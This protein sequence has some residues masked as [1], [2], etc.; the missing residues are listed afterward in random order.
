MNLTERRAG[1]RP[2]LSAGA[3]GAGTGGG[4]NSTLKAIRFVRLLRLFKLLR[5]LRSVRIFARWE[6]RMT[7]NYAML[8]LNKFLAILLLFR[9]VRY[10]RIRS[11]QS[12]ISHPASHRLA[13]S[14]HTSSR[15]GHPAGPSQRA[16]MIRPFTRA[17]ANDVV[18]LS[19]PPD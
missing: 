15:R 7:I 1:R 5:V 17:H 16:R 11:P 3:G 10:I 13:R 8:S 14:T 6:A 18:R 4:G 19:I 12:I 2:A 9:C